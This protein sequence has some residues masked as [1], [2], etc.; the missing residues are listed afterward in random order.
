MG[1]AVA[2]EAA[3]RGARVCLISGPTSLIPPSGAETVWVQTGE[4]MAEA[5]FRAFPGCD[6]LVMA[7]AVSDFRVRKPS[8]KKIKKKGNELSLELVPAR[9]I[10][11]ELGKC[12]ESQILVGFAAETEEGDSYPLEKLKTKNLDLIVANNITLKGAE[13][14]SDTNIVTFFDRFGQKEEFPIL[15]KDQVAK[16]IFNKISSLTTQR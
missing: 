15:S 5:V 14:G 12:R 16:N 2:R 3:A 4:E 11:G 1:Y 10:L 8:L 13:F 7:A 9:D 6:I